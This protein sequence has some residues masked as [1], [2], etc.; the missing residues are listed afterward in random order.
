MGTN[1]Y[2]GPHGGP[3]HLQAASRYDRKLSWTRSPPPPATSAPPSP[4]LLGLPSLP[5]LHGVPS[6]LSLWLSVH[7]LLFCRYFW[8]P[9]LGV[10]P[11][12]ALPRMAWMGE[13]LGKEACV[14]GSVHLLRK[15]VSDDPEQS[16]PS[17]AV[18][19]SALELAGCKSCLS[20]KHTLS[21]GHGVGRPS[22]SAMAAW[23]SLSWSPC[24]SCSGNI[25]SCHFPTMALEQHCLQELSAAVGMPVSVPSTTVATST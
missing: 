19:T 17:Q 11:V 10:F 12:S 9:P 22:L 2:R 20:I 18:A 16:L 14:P 5:S 23:A 3:G 21:W 25:T 8:G 13:G 6:P 7:G 1:H 15:Q 24:P 4:S